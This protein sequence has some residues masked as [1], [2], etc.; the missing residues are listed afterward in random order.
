MLAFRRYI[1]KSGYVQLR[2]VSLFIR[3]SSSEGALVRVR[4][5][6]LRYRFPG[7]PLLHF[8]VSVRFSQ[9]GSQH[10]EVVQWFRWWGKFP[11]GY[12]AMPELRRFLRSESSMCYGMPTQGE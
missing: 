5:I 8:S 3:A 1:V 12:A 9:P 4:R 10:S 6:E 2:L 11:G 7:P